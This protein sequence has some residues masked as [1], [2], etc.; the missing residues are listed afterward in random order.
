MKGRLYDPKV[1]RFLT[2]DP[3]V[4]HPAFGQ[5]WNPYS[6]VL[7][8]PL[9]FTDPSGFETTDTTY[10]NG[11]RD[12]VFDPVPF[13]VRPPIGPPLPPPPNVAAS[14]AGL[15]TVPV[16]LSATGNQAAS[17]P[18]TPPD[19]GGGSGGAGPSLTLSAG[20]GGADSGARTQ[21]ALHPVDYLGF[22]QN[23][24]EQSRQYAAMAAMA[25]LP[26]PVVV[27]VIT[28]G[29]PNPD[30]AYAPTPQTT[31]EDRPSALE[32]AGEVGLIV[33]VGALGI[34]L[35]AAV[36][37]VESTEAAAVNGSSLRSQNAQHVYEILRTDAAGA[38][39][40]YKYGVSGGPLNAAGL[41][42]RAETQ[43][44][45]FTRAGGA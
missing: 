10:S 18:Q 21:A 15:P 38:T 33:A 30:S 20:G 7:N 27:A 39:A 29:L 43:V 6:Y 19:G 45:A 31:P 32:Q 42:V 12:I 37:A 26:F 24:N 5:S 17:T 3:I 23:V 13:L 36:P 9:A 44:R 4:S 11:T 25:R 41:S 14:Q 1:G 34:K 16:D 35:G 2:T 40:V 28:F 22:R 8:N